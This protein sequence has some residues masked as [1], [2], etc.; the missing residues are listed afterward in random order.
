VPDPLNPKQS[1]EELYEL[2]SRRFPNLTPEEISQLGRL[3]GFD[4]TPP[5]SKASTS[6]D[7]NSKTPSSE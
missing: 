3:A 5:P 7:P 4:L 2:I 1:L 6:Q